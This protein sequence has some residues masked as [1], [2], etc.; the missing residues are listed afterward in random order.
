M[1]QI[2]LQDFAAKVAA[3]RKEQKEY[4]RS[5]TS[6][7]LANSKKLEAQVDQIIQQLSLPVPAQQ[8]DLFK[9]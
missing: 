1:Q 3:M 5:R 4:F 9:P 7:S 8:K 6:S 2:T